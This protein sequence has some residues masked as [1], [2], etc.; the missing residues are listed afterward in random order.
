MLQRVEQKVDQV[1]KAAV[2]N[3]PPVEPRAS[4]INDDLFEMKL[5]I[6]HYKAK[7]LIQAE[8]RQA[9]VCCATDYRE[10]Q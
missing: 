3:V 5:S 1:T 7:E 10:M 8:L 4:M 6:E 9:Q 2:A